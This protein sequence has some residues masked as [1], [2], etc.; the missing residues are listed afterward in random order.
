MVVILIATAPNGR[1]HNFLFQKGGNN[2]FNDCLPF[3]VIANSREHD[4]GAPVN[5]KAAFAALTIA[6]ASISVISP[7]TNSAMDLLMVFYIKALPF[8]LTG[9]FIK[10]LPYQTPKNILTPTRFNEKLK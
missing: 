3:E 2:F 7:S 10:A 6:S 5:R 1:C 4:L 8:Y 9:L